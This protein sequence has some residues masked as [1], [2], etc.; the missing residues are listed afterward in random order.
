MEFLLEPVGRMATIESY[1]L[2]NGSRRYQVRY[3]KPDNRQTKR[4]GFLT[5]KRA[6]E[7][8]AGV[9]VSKLR[10]EYIAPADTRVTVDELALTWL[11][12]QTHLKP[13]SYRP[14]ESAWRIHVRKVWGERQISGIKHTE[15][16]KWASGLTAA[17]SGATTVIRAHGV[18]ASILDDAVKDRRMLTNPARGVDLPRKVGKEHTYLTH[19]QVHDLAAAAGKYGTLILTL[20][21][22]GLRWG[23]G[24]PGQGPERVA[25]APHYRAERD[26]ARVARARR[27]AQVPSPTNSAGPWLPGLPAG[28]GMPWSG[29]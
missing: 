25:E 27:N 11:A 14:I 8:A 29:A 17:G 18:L 7:F 24:A 6:E 9:E 28:G 20:A 4:R 5:K 26:R 15:V 10:G 22:C 3:R 19:Q 12:R 23:D 2:K 13:S 21:Y 16:Q 1:T